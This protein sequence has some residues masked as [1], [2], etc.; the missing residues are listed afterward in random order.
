MTQPLF[1]EEKIVEVY[2]ATKHLSTPFYIGIMPLTSSRNAEFLHHEV[3]GIQLSD[4]AR[5][6]MARC[7]DDKE[8]AAQAS[9]DLAKSLID[10]ALECFNGIYLITPFLRYDLTVALTE[11]IHEKTKKQP[12][13]G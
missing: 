7:G 9:L 1:S 6:I 13:I 3:P 5:A 4:H 11:Y 8:K 10:A 2:E 12:T